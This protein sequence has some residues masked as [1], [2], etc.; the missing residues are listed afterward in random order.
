MALAEDCSHG[1]AHLPSA[2]P[3]AAL[4]PWE[5]TSYI[6]GFGNPLVQGGCGACACA[7]ADPSPARKGD[8]SIARA[9]KAGLEGVPVVPPESSLS[10]PALGPASCSATRQTSCKRQPCC[11]PKPKMC[12]GLLACDAA[13]VGEGSY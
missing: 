1:S 13:D 7:D 12:D 11:Q 2:A 5:L 6:L 4:Y 3:G 10:D 8:L 9:G